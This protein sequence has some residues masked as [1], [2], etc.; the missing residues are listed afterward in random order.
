VT[1]FVLFLSVYFFFSPFSFFFSSFFFSSSFSFRVRASVGAELYA[2]PRAL[3]DE[4]LLGSLVRLFGSLKRDAEVVESFGSGV[5]RILGEAN[6]HSR[7][8][9]C[10]MGASDE[11]V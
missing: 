2:T 1:D 7:L 8:S 9:C 6:S 5:V 4:L 10:D 11:E 3:G